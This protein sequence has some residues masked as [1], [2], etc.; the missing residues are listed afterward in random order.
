MPC[1]VALASTWDGTGLTPFTLGTA[2][3]PCAVELVPVLVPIDIPVVPDIPVVLE[4]LE[5]PGM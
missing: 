3:A 2:V 5:A 4:V 1:Q